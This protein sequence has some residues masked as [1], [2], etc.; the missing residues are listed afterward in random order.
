[1]V[2]RY[3]GSLKKLAIMGGGAFCVLVG[4]G[5]LMSK[6]PIVRQPRTMYAVHRTA[7]AYPFETR[8]WLKFGPIFSGFNK[9]KE[10]HNYLSTASNVSRWLYSSNEGRTQLMGKTRPPAELP[11]TTIPVARA[12]RLLK[13]CA[14]I[15][16]VGTNT[17]PIPIP[18]PTPW[19]KKICKKHEHI[20]QSSSTLTS[21]GNIDWIAPETPW[22]V[23]NSMIHQKSLIGAS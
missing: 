19:L 7:F 12:L 15:E 16:A 17:S 23:C 20:L 10:A 22:K 5:F 6:F 14:Q 13:W 2:I 21:P 8:R 3:S 11:L 4:S 18:I 9:T 1:M